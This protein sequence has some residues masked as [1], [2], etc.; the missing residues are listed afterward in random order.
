MTKDAFIAAFRGAG[1]ECVVTATE[2]GRAVLVDLKS[3]LPWC[4]LFRFDAASAE[5]GYDELVRAFL[6]AWPWH[7]P[8]R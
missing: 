7:T 1:W 5:Q 2:D 6:E 3:P 8:N 4:A